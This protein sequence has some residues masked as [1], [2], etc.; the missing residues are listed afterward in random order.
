[1]RLSEG[2]GDTKKE[3]R[4]EG[5]RYIIERYRGGNIKD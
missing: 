3:S 2:E 4:R 5:G 1:M